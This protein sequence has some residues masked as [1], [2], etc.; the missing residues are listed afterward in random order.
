MEESV[1]MQSIMGLILHSGNTK[2]DCMEAIQLAKKGEFLAAK[3]KVETANESLVKA[4]HSQTALLTQEARGEK[5]E[6]TMM[7]IHAQDHL[8][9]SITFRDLAVEIIELYER[10]LG[11]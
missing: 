1:L 9:N 11:E 10:V 5:V 2:S 8:M 4:H 7:L 3:D 6:V